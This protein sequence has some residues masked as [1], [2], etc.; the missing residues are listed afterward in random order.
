MSQLSAVMQMHTLD[1]SS[2]VNVPAGQ[3]KQSVS[4]VEPTDNDQSMLFAKRRWLYQ[5]D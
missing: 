2:A 3:R 5:F 4:A 1:P